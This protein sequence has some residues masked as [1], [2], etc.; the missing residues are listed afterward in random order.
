MSEAG[1]MDI[2]ISIPG[3][4][5]RPK[6]IKRLLTLDHI[7]LYI[8]QQ[9]LDEYTTNGLIELAERYP[10]NALPSFRK[11]INVMI[12]RVRARRRKEQQREDLYPLE[13]KSLE[14]ETQETNEA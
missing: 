11:N 3:D 10:T 9:E 1:R 8:R 4:D 13:N 6:R 5:G 2:H 14:Q 7:I 12:N